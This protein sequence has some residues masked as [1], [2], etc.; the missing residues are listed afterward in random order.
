MSWPPGFK[1]IQDL[2]NPME[3]VD[4]GSMTITLGPG[5]WRVRCRC[6]GQPF[7]QVLCIVT[8]SL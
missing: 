6:D 5:A 8:F 4:F 2:I 1:P 3:A 7:L